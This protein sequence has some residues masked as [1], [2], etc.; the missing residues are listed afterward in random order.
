MISGRSANPT[1]SPLPQTIEPIKLV[2]QRVDLAGYIS[3]NRFDRLADTLLDTEG[4]LIAELNFEVDPQ[5]V[6]FMVG[7]ITADVSLQCQR[8]MQPTRFQ[9]DSQ[10]SWGLVFSEEAAKQLPRQYEPLI[11]A[12]PEVDLWAIIE[13]ELMLSLPLVAYHPEDECEASGRYTSGDELT[14]APVDNPFA[15]LASLK[16]TD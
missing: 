14:T 2:D 3:L 4:D 7:K 8:C 15:V 12:N 5:G 6:K 9:V 10:V 13:D 11:L 16:K 1:Q